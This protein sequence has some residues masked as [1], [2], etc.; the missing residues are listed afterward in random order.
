MIPVIFVSLKFS[1]NLIDFVSFCTETYTHMM[2]FFI[3]SIFLF[4]EKRICS[5]WKIYEFHL[6][7]N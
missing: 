4:G 1:K 2:K 3:D 6:C 7:W 5:A